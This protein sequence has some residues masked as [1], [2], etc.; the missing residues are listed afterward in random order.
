MGYYRSSPVLAPG[1][2]GEARQQAHTGIRRTDHYC[3][4]PSCKQH[5]N[6]P[7]AEADTPEHSKILRLCKI[8]ENY[9][10]L[11]LTN[12]TLTDLPLLAARV[13]VASSKISR[14]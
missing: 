2:R 5:S 7:D 6:I 12:L 4:T 13:A 8:Q 14:G 10:Q 3:L 11:L 9:I 1:V